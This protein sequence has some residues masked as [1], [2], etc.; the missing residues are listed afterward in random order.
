MAKLELA[1]ALKRVETVLRR[2]PDMGLQTDTTATARW[3]D[4]TRVV[5]HHANGAHVETDMPAELGG[6]GD[7]V[8][9]GWLFR[10]GIGSCAA[11]SIVMVAASAGVTLSTLEV[12]VNSRSDARG[13]F[14]MTD[15]D[16]TPIYP[17]PNDLR[18]LVRIGATG[19]GADR[20]RELVDLGMR[21]SPI[22]C[23]V[24]SAAPMSVQVE[25]VG[26]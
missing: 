22:P 1:A 15:T 23:A 18:V 2:R 7:R 17:G 26:H 5:T 25:V 4:G 24:R 3:K 19:V 20:L 10:A 9:P 13:L 6:A 21:R 8:S 11:T 14:G 16:G 12:E